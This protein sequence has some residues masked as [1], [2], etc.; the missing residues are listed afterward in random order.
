MDYYAHPLLEKVMKD[1]DNRKCNDCG[2]NSNL[3]KELGIPI[4]LQLIMVW[5][6]VSI[7][8]AFIEDLVF[9]LVLF[10]R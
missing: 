10:A 7:A 8:Q 6:C 2:K 9:K 3:S 5:F 1:R 4:G